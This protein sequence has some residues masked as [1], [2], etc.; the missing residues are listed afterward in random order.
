MK[1]WVWNIFLMV[2]SLSF[3][4]LVLPE[5]S[6]QKYLKFIFSL[7]VV[8]VIVSPFGEM[9]FNE[10]TAYTDYFRETQDQEID[11]GNGLLERLESIQT[12]QLRQVYQD[13]VQGLQEEGGTSQNDGISIPWTDIY[14]NGEEDSN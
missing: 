11:V 5:G 2:A 14:S 7:I 13:K 4:E 10:V 8:G 12:K 6:M 3:I 9:K 1:E